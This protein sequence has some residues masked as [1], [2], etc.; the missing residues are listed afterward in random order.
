MGIFRGEQS[1]SVAVHRVHGKAPPEFS[2]PANGL[3]P[4]GASSDL[5]TP[6]PRRIDTIAS[7]IFAYLRG[8]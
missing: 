7:Q 4:G 6:F 1:S 8:K 5:L 2:F 3:T